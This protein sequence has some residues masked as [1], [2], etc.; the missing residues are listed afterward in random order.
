MNQEKCILNW[1][2]FEPS[3]SKT[4]KDLITD[5]DFTDVTLSCDDE[6]IIKAHKVILSASSPVMKR[7]LKYNP[8]QSPLIYLKG[9]KFDD[10]QNMV[11]FIYLGETEVNQ[12]DLER[13]M[14]LTQEFEVN[15]LFVEPKA[16]MLPDSTENEIDK[17]PTVISMP[18]GDELFQESMET[19]DTKKHKKERKHKKS[20]KRKS[21]VKEEDG[22]GDSFV[23]NESDDAEF[24]LEALAIKPEGKFKCDSCDVVCQSTPNLNRHT[25]AKHEGVR[26]AC[27]QCGYL[28]TQVS[29]LKRHKIS[30]HF[31]FHDL[32]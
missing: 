21:E 22:N 3:T 28:A 26:H 16:R 9:V 10:L 29:S 2:D 23:S 12:A 20:K 13:F 17:L 25:K 4:F 7:I 1:T 14:S 8:H 24:S 27:D 11:R 19:V 15:G 31:K 30:Q 18:Q 5:Q 6:K 32:F